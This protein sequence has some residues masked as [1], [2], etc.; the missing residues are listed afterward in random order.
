MPAL[1]P[2]GRSE[3]DAGEVA[4]ADREDNARYEVMFATAERHVKL[5]KEWEDEL[6]ALLAQRWKVAPDSG[7]EFEITDSGRVLADA[8]EGAS[9]VFHLV[10]QVAVTTSVT[11]PR[12]D[13]EVNALG[14]FNVLEAARQAASKPAVVYSSTNKVYGKLADLGIVERNG[15]YAYS[16]IERGIGEDRGP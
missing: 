4:G 5:Q 9:V 14:T 8:V 15:R 13:F 7:L 1:F 2:Y 12:H 3:E 11:D 6:I 10:G 16:N